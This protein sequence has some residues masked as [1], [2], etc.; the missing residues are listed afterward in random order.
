MRNDVANA[1]SLVVIQ[2][3]EAKARR[4]WCWMVTHGETPYTPDYCERATMT[5][6]E[7][8]ASDGC[9]QCEGDEG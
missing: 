7:R 4:W 9:P 8:E 3:A 5:E 2:A 6:D 1:V